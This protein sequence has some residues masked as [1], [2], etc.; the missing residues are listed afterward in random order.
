VLLT[1]AA[2]TVATPKIEERSAFG[3]ANFFDFS[4]EDSVISGGVGL[5]DF[6]VK[7]G[8]SFSHDRY[9]AFHLIVMNSEAT[10]RVRIALW[11]GKNLRQG[12][13]LFL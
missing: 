11:V 6:A 5:H 8:Q 4:N 10:G 3:D 1:L 9:R 2:S 7:V 12:L 13:L